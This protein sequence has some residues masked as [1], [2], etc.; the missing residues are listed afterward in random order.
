[1]SAGLIESAISRALIWVARRGKGVSKHISHHTRSAVNA[2]KRN[3]RYLARVLGRRAHTIFRDPRPKKLI[4]AAL[5]SPDARELRHGV[6]WVEKQFNRPIGKE[7]E[8][9]LRIWIDSRTG[10]IITAFPVARSFAAAVVAAAPTGAF[11]ETLEAQVETTVGG[12]EKIATAWHQ[13]HRKPREEVATAVVEFLLA[14]IGL[15]SDDAGDPDEG[16]RIKLDN[17]LDQ[18]AWGLVSELEEAACQTFADD[19]RQ[20]LRQEFKAAVAGAVLDPEEEE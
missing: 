2:A 20:A 14:A 4:E 1:M 7:G 18:Q 11:G 8:T 5:R 16:L 13:T 10:R 6:V 19:K 15:D 12:L 17:Y 9:I 3:P